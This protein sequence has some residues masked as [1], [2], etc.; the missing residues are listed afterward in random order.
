RGLARRRRN[1]LPRAPQRH[2]RPRRPTPLPASLSLKNRN[3]NWKMVRPGEDFLSGPFRFARSHSPPLALAGTKHQFLRDTQKS[4]SEFRT[5]L[6][7]PVDQ[8]CGYA[9][10]TVIDTKVLGLRHFL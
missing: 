2:R 3:R 8:R 1:Q 10:W 9:I 4:G 7:A 5:S 6:K